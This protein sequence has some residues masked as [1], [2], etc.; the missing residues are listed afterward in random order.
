MRDRRRQALRVQFDGKLRL[1]FRG[2]NG[3]SETELLPFRELD[4]VFR[5]TEKHWSLTTLREKLI[6]IGAK[7][8]SA[9]Q[10]R[11]VS[12]ARCGGT[13]RVVRSDLGAHPALRS[14]AAVAAT[15]ISVA[16]ERRS[17]QSRPGA[18]VQK[19]AFS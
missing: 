3:T 6:K 4:E 12:V 8:V 18:G 17:L 9:R 5:L 1:E 15:Q 16:T 13:A 7:A 11:D 10:V 14:A 19:K 2:A